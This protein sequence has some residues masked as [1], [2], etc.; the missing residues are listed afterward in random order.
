MDIIVLLKRTIDAEEKVELENHK[1]SMDNVQ[2]NINPY[3]EFA[4]EEAIRIKELLGGSVTVVTASSEDFDKEIRTAFAMGADEC[5]FIELSNKDNDPH[6]LGRMLSEGIKR[7][8]FDLIISGQT[9][10]DNNNATTPTIVAQLLDIP[11]ITNVIKIEI[12]EEQKLVCHRDVEGDI[13]KLESKYPL[14]ITAQ[15]G[16][17]EPRYPTLS[18]IMKAKKKK[19]EKVLESELVQSGIE[20]SVK[21]TGIYL[22]PKKNG[23]KTVTG[24]PE[25][26]AIEIFSYIKNNAKLM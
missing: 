10:I 6:Y 9:S 1:I 19:I 17:C 24:S 26:Q 7:K 20:A 16:L 8:N 15:Q 21:T 14:L 4:I 18:G 25:E 12:E 11:C 13:E 22:S 5:L 23:G 3:D 2:F